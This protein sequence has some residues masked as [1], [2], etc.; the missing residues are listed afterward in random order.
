MLLLWVLA[1]GVL[2]ALLLQL[3]VLI[4]RL[5][6]CCCWCGAAWRTFAQTR[7]QCQQQ[8]LLLCQHRC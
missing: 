2:L 6:A 7:Q 8:H 4:R 5:H 1:G 3:L